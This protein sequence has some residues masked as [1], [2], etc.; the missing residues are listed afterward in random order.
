MKLHRGLLAPAAAGLDDVLITDDLSGRA[1]RPP[2]YEAE[3]RALVHLAHTMVDSPENILQ[4]LAEAALELCNAQTAG[5]SLLE[6]SDAGEEIFRWRALAGTHASNLGGMT[7]RDFSPCGTV[8][9]RRAPQ[10]FSNPALH[11]AY[12]D[13]VFPSLTECLLIPFFVGGRPVGTIWAMTFDDVRTFDAED[14]RILT[15]LGE[16]AA[17]AFQVVSAL[18]SAQQQ[19]AER[20]RAEELLEARIRQQAAVA[21][22]GQRALTGIELGALIHEATTVVARGLAVEYSHVFELLP[23]G[24][25]LLLRAGTGW[26]EGFVGHAELSVEVDSPSCHALIAREPVII[27]DLHSDARFGGATL[28]RDQ[29][30][31]SGMSVVILSQGR[32]YGCLSAFTARERKFTRDDSYF[33]QS[34]AN[35]L[36]LAIERKRHEQEQRERDLLRSDQMAMVGQVAAGVAHELRNPLT[37]VK[38]LVQVNIKEARSRG[39]PADDLRVIEQE[40]RRMERTLQAFLDFA[41]PPRPERRRMSLI[42]LIDQTLALVRGRVEKQKVSLQVCRPAGPVAVEGDADQLQQLLLNLAMNALDV[43]PRRGSLEIELRLPQAGWVE[44]RVSDSGPGIAPALLTRVFEPFFSGK[45]S[46]LGLG[47]GLTVSRRIAE[48]HGG[49][50]DA[51]NRPEG[52]ACFVLRLPVSQG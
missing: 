36:A 16:F 40:I 47:L 13:E 30:M 35:V 52:G 27:D 21:E 38:G 26:R 42:P 4:M 45:D 28:L 11:F 6:S 44:V 41:R 19:I 51:F 10:L 18:D 49:S 7:P 15:S 9:D 23:D 34:V 48:D 24:A 39:L 5:I 14:V 12:L 37:S 20:R 22:L 17:T 50:L 46:G 33:L 2:E 31:V 8:L 1:P 25:T 29:G 32:P 3:N 43:V